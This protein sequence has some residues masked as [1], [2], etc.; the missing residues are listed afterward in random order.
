L[1]QTVIPLEGGQNCLRLLKP[2]TLS[3]I[4]NGRCQV[5]DWGIEIDISEVPYL[6]RE[7]A[8]K[9]LF[10]LAAAEGERLEEKD[11]ANLVEI[12]AYIDFRQFSIDRSPPRYQEG[13]VCSNQEKVIVEWHD[14]KREILSE[15]PARALDLVNVGE[16]FSAFVKLGNHDKA[17]AID[18]VSL[19][20]PSAEYSNED[21]SAWPKKN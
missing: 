10:L 17:V 15:K 12:S 21:W 16:K 6:P 5:K 11:Q 18:R 8:R 4:Q 14:G 3:I 9:F 13:I 1:G 7:I 20:G 19:L 2:I